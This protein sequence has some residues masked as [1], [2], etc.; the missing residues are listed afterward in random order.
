M[1]NM[2]EK[3]K[4]G[5]LLLKLCI[6]TILA[7]VVN[8]LY[9]VVDRIYIGQMVGSLALTGVG[10][11]MPLITIA[12]AFAM[13]VAAGGAP[14]AAIAMGA[15]DN[16]KAEK[17]M[18]NC[19]TATVAV[20]V[21]LT[22]VLL[23]FNEQ[24]LVL[25]GATSD[26]LGYAT[27]YMKIYSIGTI[28][29]MTT[30]GMNMFIT[31]Q[32]YA[33]I[34][35]LTVIIGAGLNIVLDPLFIGVFNMGVAGAAWATVISQAVSCIFVIVFLFGKKTILKLKFKNMRID[36]RLV[37]SCIA[38]GLSPFVMQVT[39]GILQICFNVQLRFYGEMV[40]GN[41]D[42]IAL[43]T[44]TILSSVMQF[45][46]L[47]LSGLTQGAQPIVSYNFGARHRA[48]IVHAIRLSAICSVCIMG[49][50]TIL[51]QVGARSILEV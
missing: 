42:T 29:V 36:I 48:R 49:A 40:G 9:N 45:S 21:I 44:M 11:C 2:L 34:S 31:T 28:F 23:I 3:E 15:K 37:L 39:E 5:K 17:I 19:L 14:K 13:L 6:P 22:T 10:V 47:P 16:D 26:S 41:M 8:V 7:Q 18:S 43:G 46:F 25:V 27:E 4:I 51:F 38:L 12:S 32:G 35:M 33:K 50:G 24:L 1:D 20:G 30:L